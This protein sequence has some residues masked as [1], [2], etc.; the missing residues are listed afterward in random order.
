MADR[1]DILAFRTKP[2]WILFVVYDDGPTYG[3]RKLGPGRWA[4][5]F[6]RHSLIIEWWWLHDNKCKIKRDR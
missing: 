4:F 2:L 1:K 5:D 3:K 6:G